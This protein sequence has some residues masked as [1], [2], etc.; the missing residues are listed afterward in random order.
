MGQVTELSPVVQST[1]RKSFSEECSSKLP[2]WALILILG[3]GLGFCAAVEV[4]Q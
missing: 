3:F 1:A 2:G 4:M